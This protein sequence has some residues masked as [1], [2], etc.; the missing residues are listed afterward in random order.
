M[1]RI[2]PDNQ[3]RLSLE[4]LLL[5]PWTPDDEASLVR[6]AN[7]RRIWRNVRDRFPHPYTENDAKLWI[8]IANRDTTM[9]NLAI[10]VDGHAVGDVGVLFKDDVYRRSAEIGY[11]LG[12]TYWNR[13]LASRAVAA[14]SDYVFAYFDIVRLYANVF[15]H[16]VASARVLEK[17]GYTLEAR[18]RQSVFKDGQILDEMVYARLRTLE[19]K[20]PKREQPHG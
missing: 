20:T 18:L 8:K 11:W 10:E 9:L 12:E 3:I 14:V 2:Q 16:N 6:H 4:G 15:A 1:E 7:N 19:D 13:G 17:A 5:R